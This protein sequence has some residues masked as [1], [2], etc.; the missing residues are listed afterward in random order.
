MNQQL[1][2]IIAPEKPGNVYERGQWRQTEALRLEVH[3]AA[4]ARKWKV[5]TFRTRLHRSTRPGESKRHLH[6]VG[7]CDAA[8]IYSLAHMDD[9]AVIQLGETARVMP[10]PR[11]E[12]SL[13]RAVTLAEFVLHKAFFAAVSARIPHQGV[14]DK[15]AATL[16]LVECDGE[17][18]PRCLPMHVF[19]PG[20]DHT[21]C[22]LTDVDAFKRKYGQPNERKDH[23][24]RLWMK[25][26]GR[27][28]GGPLRIRG[29]EISAGFHWDVRSAR[30]S[31]ELTTTAE[32]WT[33]PA[34]SYVNVTPNATV[35]VGQ[36]SARAIAKKSL[37]LPRS[38]DARDTPA[39][40]RP[41]AKPSKDPQNRR[42]R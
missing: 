15:F 33:L 18:D 24:G 22:P 4:L 19:A 2:V 16:E 29:A 30:N 40:Q 6:L 5:R 35:R 23:H 7:G 38:A 14:F 13:D 17:R 26:S 31:S 21:A 34:G 27:H 1:V 41:G 36:R 12:P 8:E 39:G 25:P 20:H 37:T 3:R 9:V 32:V 28:G 10:H 42:K 11:Q